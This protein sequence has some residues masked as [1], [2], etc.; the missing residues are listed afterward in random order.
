MAEEIPTQQRRLVYTVPGMDDVSVEKNIG[1][2]SADGK[3]LL[4]D[5]YKPAVLDSN[6]LLPG[7]VFIHGG[8]V[9][10]EHPLKDSGQYLSWGRLA[11]ASGLVGVTFSHN[12]Y[13]PELLP[14]SA[15][16]VMDAIAFVR[17]NAARFQLDPQRLC[18]WTCSGGGPHI[19]FALRDKP[20]FVR[21]LVSYYAIMD[22]R[23]VE[24]L[25]NALSEEEVQD[26]SAVSHLPNN[27]PSFPIFMARAGL[28]HPGLNETIDNFMAQALAANFDIEVMNHAQGQ[29]GFD[30][31]EDDVRS[32][33]IIARTMAFIKENV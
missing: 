15:A 9:P 1:Y 30:I 33:Q 22:V 26:Y 2:K 20:D 4:M 29:H 19:S 18:L 24:F 14:Q 32:K 11:A 31:L 27:A 13:A 6:T 17:D 16:N 28:D 3:A 8:P 12:Y 21:C 25:V 10:S 23:P 7:V 5:V